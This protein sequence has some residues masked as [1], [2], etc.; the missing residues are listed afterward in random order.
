MDIPPPVPLMGP[1]IGERDT[2][3][4]RTTVRLPNL[5][6]LLVYFVAEYLLRSPV[7][8]GCHASSDCTT[9]RHVVSY[10]PA[11]A[12]SHPTGLLPVLQEVLSL[13]KYLLLKDV[14][15]YLDN[16]ATDVFAAEVN[17]IFPYQ[18]FNE[19]LNLTIAALLRELLQHQ[20]GQSGRR[21]GGCWP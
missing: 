5:S 6:Y 20:T 10:P 19:I 8:P 14:L 15:N 4:F 9:L 18:T 12:L 3:I 2:I 7:A 1:C 13:A 11:W 17:A 21:G 16:Q